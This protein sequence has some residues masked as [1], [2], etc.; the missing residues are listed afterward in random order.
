VGGSADKSGVKQKISTRKGLG[1]LINGVL[2]LRKE[3]RGRDGKCAVGVTTERGENWTARFH[4]T[5]CLKCF[6]EGA[7][8][9][10]VSAGREGG[11]KHRGKK[12]SDIAPC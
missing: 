9:P 4:G 1:G 7:G 10:W 3:R 11:T 5:H 2:E 12:K 8:F 6:R